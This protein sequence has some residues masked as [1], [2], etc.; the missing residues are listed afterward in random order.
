MQM[1]TPLQLQMHSKN[2]L[3]NMQTLVK[4]NYLLQKLKKRSVDVITQL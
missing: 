4:V 1:S 2:T 3:V